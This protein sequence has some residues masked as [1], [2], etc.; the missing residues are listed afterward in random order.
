MEKKLLDIKRT[1][2]EFEQKKCATGCNG[3]ATNCCC[4]GGVGTSCS[5][6]GGTS[7]RGGSGQ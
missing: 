2:Y 7:C 3:C 1:P 5:G 4:N 6:S